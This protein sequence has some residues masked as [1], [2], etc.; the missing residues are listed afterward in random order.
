M[1][2]R[3]GGRRREGVIAGGGGDVDGEGETEG[4]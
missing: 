4:F 2:W 1:K 3:D